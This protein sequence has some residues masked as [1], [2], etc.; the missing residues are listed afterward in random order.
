MKYTAHLTLYATTLTQ[1]YEAR[2][3]GH[4]DREDAL[5]DRL[6]RIW[7]DMTESERDLCDEVARATKQNF[8]ARRRTHTTVTLLR[9]VNSPRP[10]AAASRSAKPFEFEPQLAYG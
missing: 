7:L 3:A 9:M 6:D 5:L 1:R 8:Y 10:A 2:E 4:A